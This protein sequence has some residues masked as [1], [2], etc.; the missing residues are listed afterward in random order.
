[1]SKGNQASIFKADNSYFHP[2]KSESPSDQNS[3]DGQNLTLTESIEDYKLRGKVEGRADK[4]MEQYDYVLGRLIEK[5]SEDK[6]VGAITTKEMRQYFAYLMDEGLKNTSV[7][8]HYRVLQAFFNWLVRENYISQSPLSDVQ[9]PKTPNKFP[10]VIDKEQAEKL[11]DTARNWRRTWAGY[12]NFTIIVT[13]L[14]TGL[15]LNELINA[16]LGNLD[17]EQRSIKVHGKGAKD[18][19]VYFGKNNYKCL[20]HWVKMRS[21]V[22]QILDDTVFISQKGDKLKKRH[23]QQVITRIQEEAGLED[24]QVSPHVLRHTAATLAVQNGLDTFSLKRQFG[25]EQMSTALKY[26]HMSD[27]ALQE[28]YSNSSPM[29][30]LN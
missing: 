12:R 4:T 13:F 3:A 29:D 16:K 20:K 10:K 19:R 17:L 6:Q 8:I 23:V 25:W 11:L 27:K 5:F 9:E 22:D 14:D 18:R 28:S 7:A 1:M 21:N 30:N 2:P 15:R 24:V 26:V